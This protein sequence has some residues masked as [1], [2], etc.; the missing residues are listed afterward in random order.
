MNAQAEQ[1]KE[2]AAGL[3]AIVGGDLESRATASVSAAPPR[4]VLKK[5]LSFKRFGKKADAGARDVRPEA[6]IPLDDKDF[7]NF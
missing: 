4:A 6:V 1:M 2:V 7:K 3:M 5:V